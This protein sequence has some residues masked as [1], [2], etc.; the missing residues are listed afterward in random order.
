MNLLF[1]RENNPNPETAKEKLS[2]SEIDDQVRTLLPQIRE[3]ILAGIYQDFPETALQYNLQL[4]GYE[5]TYASVDLLNTRRQDQ[6]VSEEQRQVAE[7][8]FKKFNKDYQHEPW[9]QTKS[10][11]FH[12]LVYLAA[13]LDTGFLHSKENFYETIKSILRGKKILVLGDDTGSLSEMLNYFGAIAYGVE[14]T[15]HKV[16]AAHAGVYAEDFQ[17]QPQVLLGDIQELKFESSEL[18][19]QLSQ[20]S[21]FDVIFSSAVMRTDIGAALENTG[22]TTKIFWYNYFKNCK[23]LLQPNGF[24]LHIGCKGLMLKTPPSG[25]NKVYLGGEYESQ[26]FFAVRDCFQDT[27]EWFE[28]DS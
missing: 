28:F 23:I 4:F 20:L 25:T 27:G 16:E 14:D 21:K 13:Y 10:R 5:N 3:Q 18:F 1:R 8:E 6:R 15:S 17:P 24:H 9:V 22:L 2:P 26:T 12:S 19:Q 11:Q 7:S